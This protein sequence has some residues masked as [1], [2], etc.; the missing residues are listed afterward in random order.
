MKSHQEHKVIQFRSLE[1]FKEDG[2]CLELSTLSRCWY[3]VKRI[4]KHLSLSKCPKM[5]LTS[6]NPYSGKPDVQPARHD[7]MLSDMCKKSN[8][9]YY[10][11][12]GSRS[13]TSQLARALNITFHDATKNEVS[14]RCIS[15]GHHKTVSD[16]L[17]E[18][19]S[20][21]QQFPPSAKLRLLEIDHNRI[22]KIYPLNEKLTNL[23]N[24]SWLLRAEKIL[25][26]EE[27]LGL[28]DKIIHVCHFTKEALPGKRNKLNVR[29]FG[30]PFFSII[31]KGETLAEIKLRIKKKLQVP[32]AEFSKWKFAQSK[33]A[34]FGE[35]LAE[36]KLRSNKKLQIPDDLAEIKLRSKKKS[37]VPDEEF[38][39]WNFAH[40]KHAYFQD[41]DI[42]FKHF[43]TICMLWILPSWRS[44][45]AWST[46]PI[47]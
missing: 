33:H 22:S 20:E 43:R 35:T 41:S 6:H 34:D 23:K 29:Y 21:V 45:S 2:F 4:A 47:F 5:R 36:M 7:D 42:L 15:D 39:K 16:V 40:R 18:L 44:I 24:Q 8:I 10:E 1:N 17:N 27:K 12:L 30:E 9:L 14:V 26:E 13:V 31:H 28:D 25:E 3:I 37:Q 46:L 32:D 11:I 38:S 19:K